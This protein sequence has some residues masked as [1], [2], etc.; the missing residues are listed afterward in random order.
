[1]KIKSGNLEEVLKYAK[2]HNVTLAPSQCQAYREVKA[3]Q[4]ADEKKRE[5]ESIEQERLEALKRVEIAK[6]FITLIEQ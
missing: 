6:E 2:E 3:K 1:M 4:I 5:E